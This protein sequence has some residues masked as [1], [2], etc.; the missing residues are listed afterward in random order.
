MMLFCEDSRMLLAGDMILAKITPN[1]GLW[2]ESDANPLQ[3]FLASLDKTEALH[4]HIAFTGHRAVIENVAAR[5]QELRVHHDERAVACWNA[6]E[7]CSAY[8]IALKTFRR[9]ENAEDVRMALVETLAHLE[10]LV[11]KKRMERLA[12]QVV[13]YRGI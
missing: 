5:I 13:R 10:Y 6:A 4:A 7:E 8:D 12:G 11:S 9:L 3:S 1:I 2:P